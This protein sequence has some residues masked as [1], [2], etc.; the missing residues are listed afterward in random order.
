MLKTSFTIVETIFCLTF[1]ELLN[2]FLNTVNIQKNV[3]YDHR[4]K[5]QTL[6]QIQKLIPLL[7]LYLG[8]K[9]YIV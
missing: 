2:L 1:K 8:A 3:L 7:D 9:V 4:D 6:R 5:K